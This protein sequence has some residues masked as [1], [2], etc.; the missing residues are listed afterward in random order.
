MKLV[1]VSQASDMDRTAMEDYSIPDL[2][3]MENAAS[4]A[5]RVFK[6]NFVIEDSNFLIL[7]GSGNNGGDGLALARLLYSE[8]GAPLVLLTG[9]PGSLSGSALQNYNILKNYPI[10][11]IHN[12]THERLNKEIK[13]ADIIVD[14]LLGTGLN[15]VISGELYKTIELINTSER[16]K[17]SLDIPSGING[18]TGQIMGISVN[19]DITI[20][21]GALKPGNIVYPGFSYN[22][23]I[24]LSRISFPP[25]IYD[26][27][28]FLMEINL[29]EPLPPRDETGH[30]KSF[31]KI[32]IISGAGTYY[33]APVFAASAVLKCGGG[34]SRLAS[35]ESMIPVLASS[36]PESV[37]LPMKETSGQSLS[38]S[39]LGRLKEE[40]LL[41]DTVIIGPGLSL[42]SETG[43]LICQ[44]IE[45]YD[46]FLII[47]GDAISA[48]AGKPELLKGKS[49]I[50]VLTP[51]LGEMSRLCDLSVSD[52]QKNPINILKNCAR[53][54]QSMIIMK[55]AHSMI[56]FPDGRIY[57]NT[58]GNSGM[59]T[60]GSGDI[61]TGIIGAFSGLGL[62]DAEAVKSAVFVHG[63]AGDLTSEKL[64]KDGMTARDILENLPLTVKK[65]RE[66]YD[67]FIADYSNRIGII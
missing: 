3:L 24:Y 21:F 35:P 30:K 23:K 59:G 11:I 58:T 50:P 20:S 27:E 43:E 15:R 52:I 16:S 53:H 54:Y 62:S 2:L 7:C 63:A 13:E 34:F 67:Q 42:N 32:L 6:S 26:S 60:S 49:R 39:N 31:G 61:L 8:G 40:A 10:E 25:E 14:A 33:G 22:G 4:A 44:F 56:G 46:G 5:C 38:L 12:F 28:E 64:G 51:H 18:N 55:G 17:I 45:W 37:F 41:S 9:E 47:D 36:I 29:C 48:I 65:Y 57:I 1:T 66:E 19:A